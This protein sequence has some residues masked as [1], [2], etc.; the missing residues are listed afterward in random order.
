MT[1]APRHI[2]AERDRARLELLSD[3]RFSDTRFTEQ[4]NN[5][6]ATFTRACQRLD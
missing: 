2:H 4:C 5:P 1:L 6:T 3:A